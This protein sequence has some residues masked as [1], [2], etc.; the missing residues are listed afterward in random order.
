[1]PRRRYGDSPPQVGRARRVR[2]S[3]PPASIPHPPAIHA[4][5]A[6]QH[7]FKI[8]EGEIRNA[9]VDLSRD[10]VLAK[11]MT[12]FRQQAIPLELRGLSP[13]GPN[14][15]VERDCPHKIPSA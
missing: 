8:G 10:T 7:L 13:Q 9:V 1:M 5:F 3:P 15:G 12:V 6:P 4:E 14:Q 11:P 2:R